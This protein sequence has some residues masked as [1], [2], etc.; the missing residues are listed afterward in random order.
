MSSVNKQNRGSRSH[1]LRKCQL[2]FFHFLGT[3]DNLISKS[4]PHTV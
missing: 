2:F 4:V 3:Q 1:D